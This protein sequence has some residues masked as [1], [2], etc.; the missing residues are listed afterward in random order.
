MNVDVDLLKE[1]ALVMLRCGEIDLAYLI[2]SKYFNDSLMLFANTLE[3]VDS[4]ELNQQLVQ[5]FTYLLNTVSI[6]FQRQAPQVQEA[7][8][9]HYSLI[10]KALMVT[11][12]KAN[13]Q[14]ELGII[15]T[16]FQNAIHWA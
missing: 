10:L 6:K 16:A 13:V 12:S 2:T 1:Y 5:F 15:A 8:M 14:R 11:L 7:F 4:Q 3:F 9:A